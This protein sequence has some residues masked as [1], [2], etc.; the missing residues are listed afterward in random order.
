MIKLDSIHSTNTYAGCYEG[1]P[2]PE[3][4]LDAAKRNAFELFGDG[5][6]Y[7]VEPAVTDGK[8]P[9]CRHIL[10][11]TNEKPIPPKDGEVEGHG[12]ELLL[13][14]YNNTLQSDHSMLIKSFNEN[15]EEWN[16]LA[17]NFWY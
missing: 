12:S 5:A 13:V 16:G 2:S 7:I 3:E 14:Y 9:P 6:I 11:L 10:C 4:M 8:L 17:R 15:I 1:R